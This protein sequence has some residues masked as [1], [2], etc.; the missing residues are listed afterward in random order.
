M[1]EGHG[2]IA[3]CVVMLKQDI[4]VRDSESPTEEQ[5]KEPGRSR[6][7][8]DLRLISAQEWTRR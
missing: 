4:S 8:L 6:I 5:E 3:W 1:H 2:G 7:N